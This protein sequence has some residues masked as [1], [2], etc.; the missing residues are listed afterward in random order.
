MD[1]KEEKGNG[2]IWEAGIDMYILVCIKQITNE[3]LLI[4]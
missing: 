1:T 4:A 3:N 2:M